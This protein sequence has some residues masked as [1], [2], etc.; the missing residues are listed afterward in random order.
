M[1]KLGKKLGQI[2]QV[3]LAHQVDWYCILNQA[4]SLAVHKRQVPVHNA[5]TSTE[6][7]RLQQDTVARRECI[8]AIQAPLEGY[9]KQLGNLDLPAKQK[10]HKLLHQSLAQ[11]ME[12]YGNVLPSDSSYGTMF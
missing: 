5:E 11:A 6:F 10:D 3:F 12:H 8:E 7:Q 9:Y 2:T 4:K 1:N